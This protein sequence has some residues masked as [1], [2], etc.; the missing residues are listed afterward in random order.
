MMKKI[1]SLA[2]LGATTSVMA[3]YG[4]H[5]YLYKDPRIMGMGGA[6]VAVGG[7][8]TSVFSNPAGLVQIKKD[9]GFVVDLLG[10]GVSMS[11]DSIQD[12]IDD[13]DAAQTDSDEFALLS[14][15]S[16][17]NF[18]FGVDNYSAISKNSDAFAWSVGFLGAVDANMMIHGNGG[19]GL[20]ETTTRYYYGVN[21]G[22][23]KP[24]EMK[25][26]ILDG[27]LDGT[28]DVGANVKFIN[29]TGYEGTLSISDLLDDNEDVEDKL[30]NKYEKTASAVGLDIGVNYHFLKDSGWNPAVGASILNLGM[31][32]DDAYGSQPMTVNIGASVSRDDIPYINSILFAVDYVDL[33]NANEV[34]MYD[35]N[36]ASDSVTYTDYE[37]GGF[38]KRLRLGAQLGLIDT[39]LLTTNLNLGLYQG[40]YTAGIDLELLVFKLNFATYEEQ[41]GT[42]DVD[43]T[44]RRYMF[45]IG[46]GW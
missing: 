42:G 44:D 40:S 31:D 45:K 33:F 10:I 18:H 15:Y 8:S 39:S 6:N 23:A 25:L 1:V 41:L 43:V 27:K 36:A 28:L 38:M 5:A 17:K 3:M 22:V 21:V 9:H 13:L 16:G 34:R 20:L 4:E 24:Y 14:K 26:G 46:T 12:L 19:N 32:L 11:S 30:E 29:Q 35:Y 2:L 7:Y 37:D